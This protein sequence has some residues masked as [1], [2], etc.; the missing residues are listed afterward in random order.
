MDIKQQL[1]RRNS[2]LEELNKKIKLQKNKDKIKYFEK[3]KRLTEKA[4]NELELKTKL[5]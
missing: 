2:H 3:I 5:N 4:I 1:K